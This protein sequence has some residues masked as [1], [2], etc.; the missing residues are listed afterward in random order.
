MSRA[1]Y[2]LP[3]LAVA[4]LGLFATQ[5]AAQTKQ[6]KTAAKASVKKAPAKAARNPA[7]ARYRR[8]AQSKPTKQRYAEIERA[9]NEHGYLD[10]PADGKWDKESVD[11]LKQFQQD[12]SLKDDGKLGALT[13]TALGLGPKRAPATVAQGPAGSPAPPQVE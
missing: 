11:A 12:Q 13:L 3:V 8:S 9:L 10:T 1:R 5:G 4:G 2:I 7:E 6:A